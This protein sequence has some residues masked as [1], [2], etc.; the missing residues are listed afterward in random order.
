MECLS[1]SF[2]FA[3]PCF[4]KINIHHD[5]V[6]SG[7]ELCT[8]SLK[9]F[10]LRDLRLK[11]EIFLLLVFSSLK[12]FVL[13]PTC[14][15]LFFL[16]FC[17]HLLLEFYI[18]LGIFYYPYHSVSAWAYFFLHFGF[19]S[20]LSTISFRFANFLWRYVCTCLKTIENET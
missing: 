16:I 14:F 11:F 10:R 4:Y 2:S 6:P 19:P 17:C 13:G 9:S 18:R 3:F 8:L 12:N 15:S 5:V 7:S 1:K 20:Y